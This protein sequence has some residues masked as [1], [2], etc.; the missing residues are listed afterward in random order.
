VDASRPF[1][2]P[3]YCWLRGWET[4]TSSWMRILLVGMHFI[5]LLLSLPPPCSHLSYYKL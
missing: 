2:V 5:C 3:N 4:L 1:I